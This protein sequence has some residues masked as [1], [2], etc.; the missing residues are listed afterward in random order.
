MELRNPHWIGCRHFEVAFATD[1]T[2]C[3]ESICAICH[4]SEMP[5][6]LKLLSRTFLSDLNLQCALVWSL[7]CPYNRFRRFVPFSI[8][9]IRHEPTSI[10]PCL[11][12]NC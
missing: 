2:E 3:I 5:E 9:P 10:N 12:L 7:C 1:C 6:T 11:S 8:W 4:C